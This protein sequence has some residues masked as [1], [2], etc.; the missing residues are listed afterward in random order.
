M[1][2]VLSRCPEK[3][4]CPVP[5][6]TLVHGIHFKEPSFA[7]PNIKEPL[8]ENILILKGRCR[9]NRKTSR[10]AKYLGDPCKFYNT[11]GPL[12]KYCTFAAKK[13]YTSFSYPLLN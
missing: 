2:E 11:K 10:S 1:M 13:V 8:W 3:L 7:Y 4:H 6:E 5:L 9:K 12:S